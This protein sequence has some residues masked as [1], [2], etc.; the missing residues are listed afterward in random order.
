MRQARIVDSKVVQD[1]IE[2]LGS[3]NS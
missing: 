3:W 1:A 2:D